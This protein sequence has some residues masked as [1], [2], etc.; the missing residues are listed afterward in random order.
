MIPF[1]PT[2]NKY[3]TDTNLLISWKHEESDSNQ[4]WLFFIV[5]QMDKNASLNVWLRHRYPE[6]VIFTYYTKRIYWYDKKKNQLLQST[7]QDIALKLY[8]YVVRCKNV[9]VKQVV[10][11]IS[12]HVHEKSYRM[13]MPPVTPPSP[14]LTLVVIRVKFR[15]HFCLS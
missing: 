11:S 13:M 12:N 15:L 7:L 8:V 10:F 2:C 1:S 5:Q 3:F 6:L 14:L 9:N 4:K